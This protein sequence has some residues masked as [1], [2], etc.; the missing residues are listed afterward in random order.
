MSDSLDRRAL[1]KLMGA[2]AG[3]SFLSPVSLLAQPAAPLT[4]KIP[5]SG[6]AIPVMGMGS[7]GTFNV[8]EDSAARDNCTR[9]LKAFLDAGGKL[10][11]SSPMYGSSHTVIGY[12]LAKLGRPPVFAA[13]KVWTNSGKDGPPQIEETRKAWGVPRFDLL[14]VHNLAAWEAHLPMLFAMKQEGKLR[15]VG[16]TTSHGRRHDDLEKIMRAHPLDFVQLTYNIEDREPESRLLPLAQDRGIAIIAN[17]PFQRNDLIRRF[18]GKPLPPW[19]AEIDARN[20]PQFLLKFIVSH[21][22]ITTVIPATS[23]VAHA[24]ENVAVTAGRIPD[25]ATRRRMIQ[26]VESL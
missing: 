13:D 15:Y 20:W 10:V 26:Y 1:L 23:Q 25:E 4:R 22:A 5:S 24:Q 19:A 6:E 9:V 14:Q 21:P 7:W 16:I 12:G 2:A 18:D 8:G 11:D 3:A 17:R